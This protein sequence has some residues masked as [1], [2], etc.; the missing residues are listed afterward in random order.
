MMKS[1][2][3]FVRRA[4]LLS[5]IPALLFFWVRHVNQ[6]RSR[7]ERFISYELAG[8]NLTSHSNWHGPMG[9]YGGRYDF[10]KDYSIR[11]ESGPD[12]CEYI[13]HLAPGFAWGVT[14]QERKEFKAELLKELK[15]QKIHLDLVSGH[16]VAIGDTIPQV[17]RK[18]GPPTEQKQPYNGAQTLVYR[19]LGKR[20]YEARY[21]F[22]KGRLRMIKLRDARPPDK[23]NNFHPHGGCG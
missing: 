5:V 22:E 14:A 10:A 13:L 11:D 2:H 1:K 3:S 18:I 20:L 9:D 7:P 6:N 8:V 17:I 16:G 23:I 15:G 19:H 21:E 12:G 4:A